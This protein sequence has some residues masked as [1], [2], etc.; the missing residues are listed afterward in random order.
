MTDEEVK[1]RDTASTDHGR[2]ESES[3]KD[4]A[5]TAGALRVHVIHQRGY[6][7]GNEKVVPR[8]GVDE[9]EKQPGG[10]SR[11]AHAGRRRSGIRERVAVA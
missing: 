9:F 2:A 4:S 7:D 10:I 11:L 8:G 5:W 3:G 1:V 6:W